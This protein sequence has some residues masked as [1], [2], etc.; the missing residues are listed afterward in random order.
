MSSL[1]RRCLKPKCTRVAFV[2]DAKF[3]QNSQ[4]SVFLCMIPDMVIN[5]VE[6]KV[7]E[8]GKDFGICLQENETRLA[9]RQCSAHEAIEAHYRN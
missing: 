9:E 2:R 6:K 4:F 1:R 8:K 5:L 3:V 7:R